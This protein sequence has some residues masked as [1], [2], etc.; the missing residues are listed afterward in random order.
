MSTAPEALN[1]FLSLV[2][3]KGIEVTTSV[4]GGVSAADFPAFF[5][6]F[7]VL[8]PGAVDCDNPGGVEM[9]NATRRVLIISD[10]QL[11]GF[12]IACITSKANSGPS[13]VKGPCE[14]LLSL[15]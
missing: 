4:G 13:C 12:L 1:G 6:A 10:P 15:S 8:S 11:M 9:L 7:L 5:V 3:P 2:S 14:F